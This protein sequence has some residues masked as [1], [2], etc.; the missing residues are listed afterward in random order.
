MKGSKMRYGY[1]IAAA[2]IIGCTA[3]AAEQS[4]EDRRDVPDGSGWV[5]QDSNCEIDLLFPDQ[6][7]VIV[8][9]HDDHHDLQIY[10][11]RMKGI[12]NGKLIKAKYSAGEAV[13]AA[14]TYDALGVREGESYA[15]IGTIRDDLL[16]RVAQ[17]GT[18][19]MYRSGTLIADLKMT[20]FKQAFAAMQNCAAALPAADSAMSAADAAKWEGEGAPK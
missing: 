18:L 6:S 12:A 7:G 19:R 3:L 9:I 15:Y 8:S 14:G 17:S 20:G 2:A 13:D 16:D 1:A 10:D 11:T 4:A 5:I